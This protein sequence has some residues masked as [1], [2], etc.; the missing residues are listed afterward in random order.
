MEKINN[1]INN[2]KKLPIII[3][4]LVILLVV[5]FLISLFVVRSLSKNK[6]PESITTLTN[7][8]NQIINTPSV[9]PNRYSNQSK[10]SEYTPLPELN[11]KEEIKI[12]GFQPLKYPVSTSLSAMPLYSYEYI[13]SDKKA[14]PAITHEAKIQ[15]GTL[16]I[17]D[18]Q[19]NTI[20]R[21]IPLGK[22]VIA[23][24]FSWITNNLIVLVEQ[25]L[26][27][28][29]KTATLYLVNTISGVKSRAA[30]DSRVNEGIDVHIGMPAYNSAEKS[31]VVAT[32]NE[33]KEWQLVL[34]K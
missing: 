6:S 1:T 26:M 28:K 33:G 25:T 32:T 19:K 20:F 10:W 17:Y 8:P 27:N 31:V 16:Y 12:A 29:R 11:P 13:Q 24:N 5:V 9:D 18:I 2:T 34:T 14:S 3:I 22:S 23:S 21:S 4:T 7:I 30:D 15:D